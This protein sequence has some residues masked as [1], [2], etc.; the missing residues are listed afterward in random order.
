MPG[1]RGG[2][3]VTFAGRRRIHRSGDPAFSEGAPGEDDVLLADRLAAG[4]RR[5]AA[6]DDVD[7]GDHLYRV[8][9]LHPGV[10]LD[11]GQPP[12]S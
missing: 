7:A 12:S 6:L 10:H 11:E 9:H 1:R 8:L 4:R 5:A 2:K 3:V